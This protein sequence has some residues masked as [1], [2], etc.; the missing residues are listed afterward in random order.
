MQVNRRR[1]AQ[2]SDSRQ[3]ALVQKENAGIIPAL[4]ASNFYE[5]KSYTTFS[6]TLLACVNR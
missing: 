6:P 5:T 1:L 3:I 4:D 2:I